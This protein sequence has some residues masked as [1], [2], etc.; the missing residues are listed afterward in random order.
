MMNDRV[1]GHG[2][3]TSMLGNPESF[4]IAMLKEENVMQTKVKINNKTMVGGPKKTVLGGW[5]KGK[6]GKK[7]FSKREN[8]FS[9]GDSRSLHQEKGSDKENQSYK[10][11]GKDQRRK[12]KKVQSGLS[13]TESPSEEGHGPGNLMTGIQASLIPLVQLL[14]GVARDILHGWR[15][16]L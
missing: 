8:N 13:A 1:F 2:T 4:R 7:G 5:S 16:V 10:G 14:N 9:E 6:K 3:T 11:K 12:K 15:Q